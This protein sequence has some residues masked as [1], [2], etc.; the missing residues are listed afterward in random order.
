LPRRLW[1]V[2]Q[3]L[4]GQFLPVGRSERQT[5]AEQSVEDDAE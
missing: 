2:L 4:A 5:V 3:D 1:V